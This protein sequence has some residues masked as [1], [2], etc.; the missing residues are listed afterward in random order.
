MNKTYI[1]LFVIIALISVSCL[2]FENDKKKEVYDD[3]T[4]VYEFTQDSEENSDTDQR[5]QSDD[6]TITTDTFVTIDINQR[7]QSDDET[8][9]TDTFAK[10]NELYTRHKFYLE[11]DDD[12]VWETENQIIADGL[13][14]LFS[15]DESLFA[16]VSSKLPFLKCETSKDGSLRVYTWDI[17]NEAGTIGG[18]DYN[19]IVQYIPITGTP[20]AVLIGNFYCRNIFLINKNIYLLFG[21]NVRGRGIVN[22]DILTFKIFNNILLPHNAFNNNNRLWFSYYAMES[23]DSRYAGYRVTINYTYNVETE[24][25]TITLTYTDT[26]EYEYQDQGSDIEI[27]GLYCHEL[28]FTY[29]GDEF[30]GDYDLLKQ[31][32]PR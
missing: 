19:S 26:N 10:L 13:L 17:K 3:I 7:D 21:S 32:S 30:E 27:N 25:F 14:A 22:C 11:Y 15:S 29:N 12:T 5:D 18:H 6:K 8:T 28:Q 1:S 20:C 2:K 4:K 23:I 16:D 9:A 24:P 31:L